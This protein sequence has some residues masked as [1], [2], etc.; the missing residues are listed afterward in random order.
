MELNETTIKKL[1][2][3]ADKVFTEKNMDLTISLLDVFDGNRSNYYNMLYLFRMFQNHEKMR[4]VVME[5]FEGNFMDK[6]TE[7]SVFISEFEK[8]FPDFK[9][10]VESRIE[11]KKPEYEDDL[12][13]QMKKAGF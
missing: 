12:E 1:F 11:N 6:T 5:Q 9:K 7:I 2:M 3:Y 8:A 13:A 4:Y 10:E